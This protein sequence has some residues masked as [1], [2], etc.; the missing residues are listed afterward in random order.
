IFCFTSAATTVVG[1]LTVYHPLGENCGVEI[2]SPA[3]STLQEDCRVHP[4]RRVNTGSGDVAEVVCAWAN[5]IRGKG[6]R[7]S[8][9]R[10][11]FFVIRASGIGK[12]VRP[13][14]H[15]T[16]YEHV[17]IPGKRWG[18]ENSSACI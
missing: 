2:S 5:V 16:V 13:S 7:T 14:I 4:S 9:S 10:T 18:H 3:F 1:T 11:Q 17:S 12:L 15:I 6:K 8:V